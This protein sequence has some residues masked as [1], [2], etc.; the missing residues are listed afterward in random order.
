MSSIEGFDAVTAIVLG[1]VKRMVGLR[2]KRR[3][4]ENGVVGDDDADAHGGRRQAA[5]DL[6]RGVG[7]AAADFVGNREGP[8][9]RRI[10]QQRREFLTA[11]PAEQIGP[12]HA[13]AGDF[14]KDLQHP[15]ADS[16][17][18]AVVDRFEIVEAIGRGST[19]GA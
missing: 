2:Q 16:M 7:E 12:A 13:I 11:E 17:A 14:G 1:A 8:I 19:P 18:E 3:Y 6:V 5:V 4:I 15:V 10:D 9:A